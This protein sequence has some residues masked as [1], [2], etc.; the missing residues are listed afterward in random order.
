LTSS[1][2]NILGREKKSQKQSIQSHKYHKKKS[3]NENDHIS[4]RFQP[5]IPTNHEGRQ[6]LVFKN[7]K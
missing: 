6:R 7:E 1:K 4:S 3:E 2:F 5:Y